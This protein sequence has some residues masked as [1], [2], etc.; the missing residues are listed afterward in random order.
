M[1][2]DAGGVSVALDTV[3]Y[4]SISN[5]ESMEALDFEPDAG[6]VPRIPDLL[7]MKVAT[8]KVLFWDEV[9]SRMS[10]RYT[11]TKLTSFQAH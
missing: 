4:A 8:A 6:N 5:V 1:R 11:P 10:A 3:R 9:V 7:P 2:N